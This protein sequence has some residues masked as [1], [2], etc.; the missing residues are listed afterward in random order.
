[1]KN[2]ILIALYKFLR[3]FTTK[4]FDF[5]FTLSFFLGISI[6]SENLV[7]TLFMLV[8]HLLFFKYFNT[9]IRKRFKTDLSYKEYT[10]DIELLSK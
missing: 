5:I 1:M 6:L 2:S 10:K 7:V 9:S 3:F 8:S 4:T